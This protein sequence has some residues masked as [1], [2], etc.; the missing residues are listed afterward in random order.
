MY[1]MHHNTSTHV[2]LFWLETLEFTGKNLGE[3]SMTH[4]PKA[5]YDKIGDWQL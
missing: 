3:G 4:S 1:R 5:M 2:G